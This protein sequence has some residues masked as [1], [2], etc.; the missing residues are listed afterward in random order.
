LLP[1]LPCPPPLLRL[2]RAKEVAEEKVV[3]VLLMPLLVA[4]VMLRLVAVAVEE[5]CWAVL[6]NGWALLD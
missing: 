2:T 1:P 3:V 6:F 4:A 5:V